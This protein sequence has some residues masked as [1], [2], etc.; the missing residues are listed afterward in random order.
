MGTMHIIGDYYACLTFELV[1]SRSL[2]QYRA[3]RSRFQQLRFCMSTHY[4]RN[5][6]MPLALCVQPCPAGTTGTDSAEQV[7]QRQLDAYNAHD[8][9]A[10]MAT[11][12]N[13]A[14]IY[15][16][17]AKLLMKG[18]AQI[19]D[20]YGSKRFNDPKLHATIAKRIVMGDMVID[21]EKIVLTY[22]EGP[23][24]LEAIAIYEVHAGKIT[25]VTLIRGQRILAR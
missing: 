22:P 16:Y 14:E 8:V 7:V 6:L 20:F 18:T 11:Y 5:L 23:G 25:K 10:F 4:I 17:P 3:C 21:H 15:E 9:H 1:D 13:D 24:R 12:A 19:E 2:L